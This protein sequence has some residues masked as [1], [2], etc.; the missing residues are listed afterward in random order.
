MTTHRSL[1]SPCVP[2]TTRATAAHR[3][4]AG[5]LA[6]AAVLVIKVVLLEIT[7]TGRDTAVR[8]TAYGKLSGDGPADW[9]QRRR[10]LRTPLHCPN[11]SGC[12]RERFQRESPQTLTG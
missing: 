12:T 7:S 6:A 9:T 11:I 10:A 4:G 8:M 5:L 3:R 2:W 1:G